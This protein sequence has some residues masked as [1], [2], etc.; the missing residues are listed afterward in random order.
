M[1]KIFLAA[2]S[3]VK[4]PVVNSGIKPHYILESFMDLRGGGE[5]KKKYIEWCLTADEFL[6]DSGAFTFINKAKKKEKFSIEEINSYCREYVKFI[7]QY[8]IKLFFEMDLDCIFPYEKVKKARK[9]IEK[10]TGKKCI[11]VWHIS[12]GMNDFYEMCQEYD[13]VAVGGIAAKEIKKKDY[14]LLWDL[15]EIAHSYGCKVHG[16][17]YLPIGLLNENACPFDTVDGTGWQGHMRAAKFTLEGSNLSKEI[18]TMLKEKQRTWK[19]NIEESYSIW[20]EY[21]KLKEQNYGE[22]NC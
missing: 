15:C 17:G 4:T 2:C 8:D 13:Y 18:D 21:S 7:N 5:A 10:H 22:K 20:T 9:W 3:H 1:P 11:P 12:R 16:L 14:K 6:L 19:D